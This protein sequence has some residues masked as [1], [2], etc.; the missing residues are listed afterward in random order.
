MDDWKNR[1]RKGQH[2]GLRNGAFLSTRDLNRYL[3]LVENSFREIQNDQTDPLSDDEA[4]GLSEQERNSFD[5]CYSNG[6]FDKYTFASEFYKSFVM[7]LYSKIERELIGLC[8]RDLELKLLVT[9]SDA[10]S[11]GTGIYRAQ[12][13]LVQAAGYTFDNHL[14]Q[15]LQIIGK[16]RNRLVHNDF[17][18]IA[19][20]QKP[21]NGNTIKIHIENR[22]LIQDYYLSMDSALYK[23]LSKS[24]I[25]EYAG[26][27]TAPKN[28]FA[29]FE[30]TPS[31]DYC[32]Y[33]IRFRKNLLL[34][35]YNGLLELAKA[36]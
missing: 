30:I 24:N 1:F 7:S 25:L 20:T 36:M 12:R 19:P 4:E 18:Y 2:A 13:F 11:L 33:L 9:P 28:E 16:V 29:W 26:S 3:E 23:H 35:I 17:P 31:Y 6:I 14:W 21:K 27:S 22:S 15:E 5:H 34:S 8:E 32:R 10:E